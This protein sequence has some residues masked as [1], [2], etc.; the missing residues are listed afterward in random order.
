LTRKGFRDTIYLLDLGLQP[1][2][3]G[4]KTLDVP[5]RRVLVKKGGNL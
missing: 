4:F 2:E 1:H 5:F 3:Q